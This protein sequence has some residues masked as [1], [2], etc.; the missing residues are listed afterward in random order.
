MTFR[1]QKRQANYARL[2]LKVVTRMKSTEALLR[3]NLGRP[4]DKNTTRVRHTLSLR[5][6][7]KLTRLRKCRVSKLVAKRAERLGIEHEGRD[8]HLFVGS[9]PVLVNYDQYPRGQKAVA[10][11]VNEFPDLHD[12]NEIEA[13]AIKAHCKVLMTKAGH[14]LGKHDGVS[15]KYAHSLNEFTA[16]SV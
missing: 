14:R 4:P 15:S 2:A 16:L 8:R 13:D 7:Q 6:S 9:T 5:L 1:L 3:R 12:E 10:A 11:I